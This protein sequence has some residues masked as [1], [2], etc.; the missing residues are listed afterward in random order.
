[1][2]ASRSPSSATFLA[3]L[4]PGP[5]PGSTWRET[6]ASAPNIWPTTSNARGP[7]PALSGGRAPDDGSTRAS[8]WNDFPQAELRWSARHLDKA[9]GEVLSDRVSGDAVRPRGRCRRARSRRSASRLPARPPSWSRRRD[10]AAYPDLSRKSERC[11]GP[12]TPDDA[13]SGVNRGLVAQGRKTRSTWHFLA[14]TEGFEPSV[15]VR[16]LHLSRVVH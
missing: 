11:T 16:G 2:A 15:P 3:D 1:M 6:T 5:D 14:E 13:L 10:Q 9:I 7:P 4:A 8:P 12:W